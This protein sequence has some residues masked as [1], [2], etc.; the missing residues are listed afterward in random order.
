M[1]DLS[2]LGSE[3]TG[4]LTSEPP[5]NSL[6]TPVLYCSCLKTGHGNRTGLLGDTAN[7]LVGT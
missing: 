5:G 2:S 3:N 1:W 7:S 6:D 4:V